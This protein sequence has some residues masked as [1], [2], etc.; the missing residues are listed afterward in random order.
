MLQLE[1][2]LELPGV[3]GVA[4]FRSWWQAPDEGV[5]NHPLYIRPPSGREHFLWSDLYE[6]LVRGRSLVSHWLRESFETLGFTP[7]HPSIGELEHPD[8]AV[9]T[10]SRKNLKKLWDPA[11]TR[12]RRM[13]WEVE[14]GTICQLYLKNNAGS[15]AEMIYVSPCEPGGRI[16]LVRVTPRDPERVAEMAALLQ[17]TVAMADVPLQVEML[18]VSRV[19]GTRTVIDVKIPFN[20]LLDGAT[21]VQEIEEKLSDHVC[22]IAERV[23]R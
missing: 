14:A 11:R 10:R 5:L 13:G 1:R 23:Q 15:S 3:H 17:S 18:D 21:G 2:Y 16:L 9:R 7:P 4:Y 8:E 19:G 6:S 22:T 12:L 20:K